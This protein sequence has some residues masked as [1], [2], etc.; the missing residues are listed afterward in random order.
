MGNRTIEDPQLPYSS[1]SF[2]M[3]S[4]LWLG[5]DG[6]ALVKWRSNRIQRLTMSSLRPTMLAEEVLSHGLFLNEQLEETLADAWSAVL[7]PLG[8][9]QIYRQ[10]LFEGPTFLGPATDHV[11]L[12]PGGTVELVETRVERTG[13]E[14]IYETSWDSRTTQ[15]NAQNELS[16]LSTRLATTSSTDSRFGVSVSASGG[17]GPISTSV[18]ATASFGS[19]S[20][21]AH[22]QVRR[23]SHERSSKSSEELRRS[24][25]TTVKVSH[26]ETTTNQKRYILANKTDELVNYSLH[27]KMRRVDMQVQYVGTRLCWVNYKVEPGKLLGTAGLV[28]LSAPD[29]LVEMKGEE[30]RKPVG[31]KP[32]AGEFVDH[33]NMGGG[34]EKGDSQTIDYRPRIPMGCSIQSVYFMDG[35]EAKKARINYGDGKGLVSITRT[36]SSTGYGVWDLTVKYAPDT[37]AV[38]EWQRTQDEFKVAHDAWRSRLADAQ[39]QTYVKTAADALAKISQVESRPVAVLRQEERIA[40]LR[41]LMRDLQGDTKGLLTTEVLAKVFELDDVYFFVAPDWYAPTPA[42]TSPTGGPETTPPHRGNA[43]AHL[44]K[45]PDPTDKL[46]LSD[47]LVD[48]DT[49]AAH[50]AYT[51]TEQTRPAPLEASLGWVLQLDGDDNRNSFL[52]APYVKVLVPVRPG[53]EVE[54]IRWLRLIEGGTKAPTEVEATRLATRLAVEHAEE[55]PRREIIYREGYRPIGSTPAPTGPLRAN[56]VLSE[57]CEVVPTRQL[58]AVPVRYK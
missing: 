40:L 32:T 2:A 55:S 41:S 20:T 26:E 9:V 21:R 16:E 14:R 6:Q 51:I 3:F 47:L 57:W 27:L 35:E 30:P 45:D 53:H 17:F 8:I 4:P 37:G 5:D 12:S 39:F 25:K 11:W 44:G 1:A 33:W 18:S 28:H 56:G 24:V 50:R 36:G 10:Y 15:E 42:M 19:S 29:E 48:W 13:T 58:V 23:E 54:A 43:K 22:D 34:F 38:D 49:Y 46:T 31:E 52:N 7:C